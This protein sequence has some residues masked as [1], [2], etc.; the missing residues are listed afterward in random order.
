MRSFFLFFPGQLL[1][2]L[3]R[4]LPSYKVSHQNTCSTKICASSVII[5]KETKE[6][7][8]RMKRGVLIVIQ[9]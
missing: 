1:L 2:S 5:I 6:G 4:L 8:G 3:R 9:L 7:F